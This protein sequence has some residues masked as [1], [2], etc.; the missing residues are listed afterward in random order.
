MVSAAIM[1]T[2]A[3]KATTYKILFDCQCIANS[4]PPMPGDTMEATRPTPIAQPVPD[5][6]NAV[7]YMVADNAFAV[8]CAPKVKNPAK[9]VVKV[10][11]AVALPDAPMPAINSALNAYEAAN[12]R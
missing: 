11:N 5:E 8:F 10:A 7:G 9:N 3:G 2:I 12:A 6:R 1:E 4:Q